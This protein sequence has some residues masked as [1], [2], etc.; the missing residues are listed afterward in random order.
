MLR[1]MSR[2]LTNHEIGGVLGLAL[3]TV[4]AHIAA[5]FAELDVSNRTEAALVMRELGLDQ[6]P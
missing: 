6:E 5:I 1:L 2:G 3:G 4:K